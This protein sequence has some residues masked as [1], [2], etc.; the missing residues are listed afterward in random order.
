MRC[1]AP[2][3]LV[4]I[5]DWGSSSPDSIWP[6]A[7]TFT[8]RVVIQIPLPLFIPAPA[9]KVPQK[10]AGADAA[11]A[12]KKHGQLRGAQGGPLLA[13]NGDG[14]TRPASCLK[15]NEKLRQCLW[16]FQ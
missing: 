7:G 4:P 10:K 11:P 13:G 2:R 3:L 16:R 6:T 12:R 15:F 8:R 5:A 1:Q 14:S 9:W